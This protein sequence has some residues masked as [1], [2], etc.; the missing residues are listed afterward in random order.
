LLPHLRKKFYYGRTLIGYARRHPSLARRQLMRPAF[1]REWR[2]L[3]RSPILG[4]SVIA[5]KSLELG[6]A[7]AGMIAARLSGRHR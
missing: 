7:T 6:A 5:L 4:L 2:R 3:A 1:V